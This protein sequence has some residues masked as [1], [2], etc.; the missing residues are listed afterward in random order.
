MSEFETVAKVGDIPD[1]EGRA[2]EF[3]DQ[4]THKPPDKLGNSEGTWY[5]SP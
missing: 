2:F 1:G 3:G 4:A 5:S